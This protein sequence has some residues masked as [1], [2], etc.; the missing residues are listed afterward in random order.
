[1]V[2]AFGRQH[3]RQKTWVTSVPGRTGFAHPLCG[4]RAS[5]MGGHNWVKLHGGFTW[6]IVI[7][8]ILGIQT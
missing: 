5:A 3:H 2:L 1:M 7:H 4:P 6:V 8:P